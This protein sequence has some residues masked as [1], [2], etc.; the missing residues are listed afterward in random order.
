MALLFD[1]FMNLLKVALILLVG[2]AARRGEIFATGCDL[3]TQLIG[4]V[5]V[6]EL[7]L[8]DIAKIG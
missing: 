6:I 1:I 3:L 7:A 5:F 4:A 2:G 8:I